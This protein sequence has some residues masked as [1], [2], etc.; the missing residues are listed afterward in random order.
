MEG[1]W[2]FKAL[3]LKAGSEAPLEFVD[4]LRIRQEYVKWKDREWLPLSLRED[5]WFN[6]F[7]ISASYSM[8]GHCSEHHPAGAETG[9]DPR[10]VFRVLDS[11]RKQ[12]TAY[13]NSLRP[14]LLEEEEKEHYDRAD[15]LQKVRESE[16][17]L[18]SLD[19]ARNRLT[20]GNI[21]LG[22][23]HHQNS[24]DSIR[25]GVNS[26]AAAFAFNT[27]E[28]WALRFR[29]YFEER[30][31]GGRRREYSLNTR[32]GF[33]SDC[34]FGSGEFLS[35][36]DPLHSERWGVSGGVELREVNRTE[37]VPEWVNTIYSLT[38][39]RNYRKLYQSLFIKGEYRRE[40]SNG[41]YAGASLEWEDRTILNNNTS[42]IWYP[43]EG[44]SYT[45]NR[46]HPILESPTKVLRP[47]I[48]WTLRPAQ[49]YERYPERKRVTEQPYPELYGDLEAGIPLDDEYARYARVELGIGE[50]FDLG[51]GGRMRVDLYGG[52]F[53][54]GGNG[55]WTE[56]Q[57]YYAEAYAGIENIFK[58][59]RVDV[60][61]KAHPA[62]DPRP[63][64][65]IGFTSNPF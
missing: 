36:S 16:P 61:F 23:Y 17:Y 8:A 29:P 54:V 52:D 6:M 13:W 35:Y 50:Y 44:V 62:F 46:F 38:R 3:D 45:G 56:G 20:W 26:I 15:S 28:G 10:E 43:Q 58:V 18:D 49:R 55:L 64:W 53:L 51:L 5:Y 40:W 33:A 7:G 19:S 30:R 65:R 21:L 63:Y 22:G 27:V 37:P 32:Y 60:A 47:S 25:W 59:L 41:F 31:K 11:A 39:E 2:R 1:E 48:D 12:D 14:F 24:F 9:K 4:S 34:F 57:G 42:Q